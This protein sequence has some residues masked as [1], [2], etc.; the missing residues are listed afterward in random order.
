MS[1]IRSLFD[2]EPPLRGSKLEFDHP[3]AVARHPED[4]PFS[5]LLVGEILGRAIKQSD[6]LREHRR[7]T[8]SDHVVNDPVTS[9]PHSGSHQVVENLIGD[10]NVRGDP[11]R[12]DP[13]ADLVGM[14]QRG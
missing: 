4:E 12:V 11:D 14:R 8:R 9:L 6:M 13:C 7:G 5:M 1:G 10:A 2:I 3:A